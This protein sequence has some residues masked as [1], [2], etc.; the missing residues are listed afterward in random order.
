[1]KKKYTNATMKRVHEIVNEAFLAIGMEP[2]DLTD[3]QAT[4]LLEL[5]N[6]LRLRPRDVAAR[7][8][9]KRIHKDD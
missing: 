2:P 8:H 5:R 1:M 6:R 7:L 4:A 3:E 9:V